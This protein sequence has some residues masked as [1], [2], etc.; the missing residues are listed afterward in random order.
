VQPA[1]QPT[2]AAFP[3]IFCGRCVLLN[4]DTVVDECLVNDFEC[5]AVC[6]CVDGHETYWMAQCLLT[7]RIVMF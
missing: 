3:A 7:E 4:Q 5:L 2:P 6:K 1:R